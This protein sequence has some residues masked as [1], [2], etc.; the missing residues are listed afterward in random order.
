MWVANLSIVCSQKLTLMVGAVKGHGLRKILKCASWLR[1][2]VLCGYMYPIHGVWLTLLV[3]G[4]GG[5]G[6]G[7]LHIFRN[8]SKTVSTLLSYIL[9]RSSE[10]AS[11][12][13]LWTMSL[14]PRSWQMSIGGRILVCRGLRPFWDALVCWGINFKCISGSQA[15]LR[16]FDK[17]VLTHTSDNLV[18]AA[19]FFEK[20]I[21]CTR[22]MLVLRVR[23]T[24]TSIWA[25]I[26]NPKIM[27]DKKH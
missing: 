22:F 23:L 3:G 17:I 26:A 6:G 8:L 27:L 10:I 9:W 16:A 12:G 13:I 18:C 19:F 1:F 11:S 21:H 5:G 20:S 14:L 7:R 4:G 15:D 2:L 25:Q 24:K